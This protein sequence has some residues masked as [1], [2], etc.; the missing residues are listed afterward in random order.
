MREPNVSSRRFPN[1]ISQR[2]R[3]ARPPLLGRAR[4]V[5]NAGLRLSEEL[6]RGV[7]SCRVPP[8]QLG[9]CRAREVPSPAQ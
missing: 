8:V 4:P 7:G 3:E 9:P 1:Y 2:R 6:L 5:L